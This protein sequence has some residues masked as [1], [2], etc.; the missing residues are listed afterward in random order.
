MYTA[1][2]LNSDA[3]DAEIRKSF[4]ELS[5]AY[6]PDRQPTA[7]LKQAAN[8]QFH[9]LHTM[10]EVLSDPV[11]RQA[12]DEFGDDGVEALKG[13]DDLVNKLQM[14]V[15]EPGTVRRKVGKILQRQNQQE[16]EAR[17]NLHGAMMMEV[18]QYFFLIFRPF[19]Q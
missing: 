1:L 18:R 4:K 19:S 5:L 8:L 14:S 9:K 2:N 15:H 17:L 11:R 12:Y 3:S 13:K 16:L 7:E 10:Y 6:H